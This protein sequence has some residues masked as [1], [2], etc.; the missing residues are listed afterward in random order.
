MFVYSVVS[1]TKESL[2]VGNQDTVAGII[3]YRRVCECSQF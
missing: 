3:N 1:K 2:T